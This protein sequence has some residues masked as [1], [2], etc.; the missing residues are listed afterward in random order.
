MLQT[1]P[2]QHCEVVVQFPFL[3]TQVTAC[4]GVGDTIEVI[5]GTATTAPIP[6]ARTISRRDMPAS[7]VGK[8]TAS[9]NR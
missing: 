5:K 9:S 3:G 7:L 8:P 1:S 6:R 4:T 2:G